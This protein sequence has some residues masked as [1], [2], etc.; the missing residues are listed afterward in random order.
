MICNLGETSTEHTLCQHLYWKCLHTSVHDV[1]K[2]CPKCQ[3]AR[4]TN[5]KYGKLPPKQPE[6]NSWDTLCVHLIG[7]YTIPRKGKNPL[8][9]W[10]LTMIDTATGWFNMAKIPNKKPAEIAETTKKTWFTRYP[11][12]YRIVFDRGNKFMAEFV[13]MCQND[14][15]LKMKPITTRDPHSNAIIEQIHQ[16]IGNTIRTFDVSNIVNNDPW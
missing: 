2:K 5:H 10:L 12:P 1:C 9:W 15:G 3:R 6:T 4:T 16:T 8:K 7:P 13:K 11:F 14:Y